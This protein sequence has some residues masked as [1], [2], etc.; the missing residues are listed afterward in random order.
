[1]EQKPFR[2]TLYLL[3]KIQWKT[4]ASMVEIQ[5]IHMLQTL[6]R[7]P[8]YIIKY[9]AWEPEERWV[10]KELVTVN[11]TSWDQHFN[12]FHVVLF[13]HF[14]S[15]AWIIVGVNVITAIWASILLKFTVAMALHN[16]SKSFYVNNKAGWLWPLGSIIYR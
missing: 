2:K 10:Y 11:E 1:M 13:L 15:Q 8:E 5:I 12:T 16:L 3:R 9:S 6:E 7:K 14:I 4:M